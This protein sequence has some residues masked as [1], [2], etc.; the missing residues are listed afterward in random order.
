MQVQAYKHLGPSCAIQKNLVPA[1]CQ[2]APCQKVLY[3]VNS[4]LLNN[5]THKVLKF[6]DHKHIYYLTSHTCFSP[7]GSQQVYHSD[8][9][10]RSSRILD[11]CNC[12]RQIS[13]IHPI[14][15]KKIVKNFNMSICVQTRVK[16]KL[17]NLKK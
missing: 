3:T 5:A 2:C 4:N 11:T 13:T 16:L 9:P 1:A 14:A 6:V 7:L 12:Y 8:A 15:I 17:I 10:E